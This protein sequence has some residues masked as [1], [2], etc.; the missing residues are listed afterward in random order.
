MA[1]PLTPRTTASK[2]KSTANP[3]SKSTLRRFVAS[4]LRRL[5]VMNRPTYAALLLLITLAA[6]ALRLPDLA[7]RPL[8][9]DEGVNTVKFND[10]WHT[11]KFDY[12]PN[13]YHGPTLYYLTLPAVWI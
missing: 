13:E 8:H 3:R 5:S 1:A 4:W 6:L 7:A 9:N 2:S 10:L 12:D 11:A